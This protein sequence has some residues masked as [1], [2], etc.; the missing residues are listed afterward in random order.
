M[1][2]Q[3][4]DPALQ[5]IQTDDECSMEEAQIIYG[6]ALIEL[7]NHYDALDFAVDF[8]QEYRLAKRKSNEGRRMPIAIAYVIPDTFALFYSVLSAL[9]AA[10]EAGSCVVI[11]VSFQFRF[12][13]NLFLK[14]ASLT[15]LAI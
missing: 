10:L 1:L 8:E 3:R 13:C 4:Q 15:C 12:F 7:R 6:G 11:E 5:V 9:C 14:K 2:V